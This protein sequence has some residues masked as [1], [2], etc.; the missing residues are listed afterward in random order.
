MHEPQTGRETSL[1][2]PWL[3]DSAP[4]VSKTVDRVTL[5]PNKNPK[6]KQPAAFTSCDS[7]DHPD[8]GTITVRVVSLAQYVQ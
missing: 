4:A 1:F 5:G 2:D 8:T 7:F 3:L 6:N